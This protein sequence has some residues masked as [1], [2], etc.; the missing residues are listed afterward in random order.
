MLLISS[1]ITSMISGSYFHGKFLHFPQISQVLPRVAL[2]LR[3]CRLL[4]VIALLWHS[5]ITA[6][7][8][9][10]FY[11]LL[12]LL[13]TTATKTTTD[14]AHLVTGVGASFPKVP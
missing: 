4:C 12:P 11:Q 5:S 9:V 10:D 8:V 7:M 2:L 14:T 13:H 3:C 6:G 1:T